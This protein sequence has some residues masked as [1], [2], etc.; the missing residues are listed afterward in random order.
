MT[1]L[2][3]NEDPNDLQY[4]SSLQGSGLVMTR[5]ERRKLRDSRKAKDVKTTGPPQQGGGLGED[6]DRFA[7]LL[8]R[9]ED[10]LLR[11]V[12]KVN[13]VYQENLKRPAPFMTFVLCGMQS[14]GKST[15]MERFLGSALNIVQQGTGTRCPLDCTCIHDSNCRN[16]TCELYGEELPEAYH[17][18]DVPVEDVFKRIT[19]FNKNL[20]SE[21][22]FSTKPI[23]LVY[24]SSNVQN[25][26]FVDTPGIISNQS[27][28]KDNR[29]E[30]KTILRSEMRKPNTK[31]CVL[32]EPKEFATNPIL[33]FCDE[34]L[35]GHL[36]PEKLFTNRMKLIGDADEFEK[37]KFEMW[38]EGHE[39]F[40]L[41]NGGSEMPLNQEV[42]KRLR[43]ETAKKTMRE[44][45]L[46]DTIERLPEVL[47]SLRADL[48]RCNA[49]QKTL[50]DR[51]K[52]NDA[53]NLRNIVS[54][55][56]YHIQKRMESYLDGDLAISLKFPGKLQ[57]LEDE[58]DE[59]EDSDW[60]SKELNFHSQKEN[61]WRDRVSKLEEFPPEICP[62][63]KF[64]GG[65][66][67][68][69][70]LEFF[71]VIMIDAL[72]D[73]YQLKDKVANV[74][75]FLSG[76][77]QHENW[78]R[79]MVEITRVCLKDVSHPGLNYLIKHIGCI[80]RRLFSIA[81]EDVKQGEK[82]SAEF[83]L[84]PVG[85]ER[86]L[87]NEFNEMLWEL[88][89]KVSGEVHSSME[90]MY[91]SID[92]NLPTFQCKRISVDMTQNHYVKR[93]DKFIPADEDV[94]ENETKGWMESIKNRLNVFSTNNSSSAKTF[95]REENRKRATAKKSFLP[96][97]R[98]AMITKEETEMILTR[99]FEY[100]VGLLE[101][102]LF[103]FKFQLNHHFYQGFK[104]AIRSTLIARVNDADWNQ[105]V[106]P[107]PGIDSR[108]EELDGQ[109]RGLSD[110][111]RDVQRMHRSI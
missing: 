42:S 45:M 38:L 29:E 9:N 8:S 59:E 48:D 98:A 39:R 25:M 30:I 111:L 46:K 94:E 80:F 15:I 77:L 103:V 90:P 24:R 35:G 72:P 28:G 53:Q 47:N 41:D 107:D 89:L 10:D 108:L 17:G 13:K 68:Q 69:R 88:M 23:Y 66:Q 56:L 40:N 75:G 32:L 97:E 18:K 20:G 100:I 62:N 73:P 16:P 34:S 93:G 74:T 54:H 76:G 92:P 11:F 49:E 1:E 61:H 83:K 91:S 52:F 67:Y 43:F 109:I 14:A 101:F 110:S 55:M 7:V 21:D 82:Y 84:L 2:E 50:L 63:E 31:L 51:K 102:N 57:T 58:I 3:D 86:F 19:D 70:A 22:R 81:M 96:D 26:R 4:N 6:D 71:R 79:A 27:T 87:E 36:P 106:R 105:L 104:E 44:I 60:C 85:L 33:N 99:S 78:E 5:E 65:K 95:L 12:A 64:L 37:D